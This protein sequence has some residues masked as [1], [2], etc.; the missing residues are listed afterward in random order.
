MGYA[1]HIGRIGALAV[2][3]G[4]GVAVATTPG[5]AYAD[6]SEGGS[7][8]SSSDAS[9]SNATSSNASSGDGAAGTDVS[10]ADRKPSS[11]VSSGSAKSVDKPDKPAKAV[12]KLADKDTSDDVAS[13]DQDADADAEEPTSG[14]GEDETPPTVGEDAP[15]ADAEPADAPLPETETPPVQD[16]VS[17]PTPADGDSG[18]HQV[19][20]RSSNTKPTA[21][22][23]TATADTTVTAADDAELEPQT[24]TVAAVGDAPAPQPSVDEPATSATFAAAVTSAVPAPA[25]R[26]PPRTLIGGVTEFVASALEPLLRWGETS[27]I[28]IPL[29]SAVLSLVRNEFDRILGPRTATVAPQQTVSQLANPSTQ[30]SAPVDPTQQHVLVIGVDGTNLSRILADDYNQNFFELMGASTTAAASIVGHTTISNPSWTAILTGVWGERTGVTNNVFTPWTYNT[31]PTVFNQLESIDRDIQTM[32]VGNWDV[33]NAIAG[34]GSIPAD[35]NVFVAQMA[36]D[37][38]WLETD[39]AVADRTVDAISGLNG[40]TPNFLFSYFGGVDEN[41]HMYGGGSPEYAASIRNMDDNLG[42]ILDAVAARELA[43]G[44]DWTVIVVTDHGHTTE[45]GLGHGFQSPNETATFVIADGPDFKDGYINLK[46]EIVDTTPTVVSLFGGTPRAGSDGVDLTTLDGSD[47]LPD[48]LKQALKDAIADNHYPDILTN[49][50]LGLRTIVTS[51][52]YA[53]FT[54]GP[55]IV[56]GLPS[57]LSGP[58]KIIVD[59][60]YVLTN[61]PAQIVAFLTGVSGASIFPLLPPAPPNFPPAEDATLPDTIVLARCGVSGSVSESYCGAAS[62]A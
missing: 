56:A 22:R 40:P 7:G 3:L 9:T 49:V 53:V 54:Y 35:E 2:A 14:V 25:V 6:P 21:P 28:Q 13:G 43:T 39:D 8:E 1:R 44:E 41:G 5:I 55:D 57:F 60:L 20:N 51:V 30:P 33:I 31:W 12:D 17:V 4:V 59:G 32:A 47:V 37:T 45:L 61:V 11:R 10:T 38:N 29:L 58:A 48:D 46:Y 16:D 27:P 34:A 24:F 62:V 52:P 15:P 36:G 18:D 19:A 23:H 42:E 26:Q 50:R